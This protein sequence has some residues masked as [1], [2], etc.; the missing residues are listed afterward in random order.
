MLADPLA[1]RPTFAAGGPLDFDGA[2]AVKT[3][4]SQGNRDAWAVAFDDQLVIAAW[5]GNHDWRRTDGLTGASAAAPIVRRVFEEAQALRPAL[6]PRSERT[7]WLAP[8][9]FSTRTLCALSGR[10]AGALCP[11]KR[12]EIF[13]P[14][15][16]PHEECPFHTR[17]RLDVR[18]GLRAGA[19]C[20]ARFVTERPMLDLPAEYQQWARA[21][22]LEVAPQG[23]SRLCAAGAP[24][25]P[26]RVTILSPRPRGRLSRDPETPAAL[27]TIRLAA[28]VEPVEE[29]IVWL[30]DGT[31]LARV[32][33]P[34]EARWPLASG[35]HVI[36][37]VGARGGASAPVTVVVE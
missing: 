17:V 31:P 15:T 11:H 20:P 18:N 16:E 25:G 22:H 12:D 23:A 7:A 4:T 29:E 5:V 9:G 32:G 10:L 24:P 26:A 1:R 3:G 36:R 37:A 35:T 34:H 14:G 13:V 30:V 33:Y 28:L 8:E 27:A 2:V 19:A 21:A 6:R